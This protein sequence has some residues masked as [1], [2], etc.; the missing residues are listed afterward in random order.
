MIQSGTSY[1]IAYRT[2][3]KEGTMVGRIP[4]IE[5]W[6]ALYVAIVTGKDATRSL[7]AMGINP[8]RQPQI[9]EI[10]GEIQPAE[11]KRR[12]IDGKSIGKPKEYDPLVYIMHHFCG[13]P[14]RQIGKLL[15]ISDA[16]AL[17]CVRRVEFEQQE[18]SK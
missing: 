7:I 6:Y 18:R 2:S 8:S 12:Y 13:M 9:E 16:S 1:D 5:N 14:Y 15:K 4:H 17:R 11:P 3:N 10:G